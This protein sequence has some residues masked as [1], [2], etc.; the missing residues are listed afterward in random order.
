[1]AIPLSMVIHLRIKT[2]QKIAVMGI[3]ALALFIIAIDTARFVLVLVSPTALDNLLIWNMVECAVVI[4]VINAPILRPL[5][6]KRNFM[7]GS[8]LRRVSGGFLSRL[9]SGSGGSGH[10]RAQ[11]TPWSS[12]ASGEA[13]N[14][15]LSTGGNSMG[16]F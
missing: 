14:N 11:S 5:L 1:M 2:S 12:S 3:F 4:V 15:Q 16:E 10:R 13:K 8:S 6:F 9:P 7:R